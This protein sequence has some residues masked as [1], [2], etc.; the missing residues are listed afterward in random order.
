MKKQY[1]VA[2]FPTA[3]ILVLI[4]VSSAASA[5]IS[6]T[7]IT[8]HGTV[9]NPAIYGNSIAWQD[10]RNGNSTIYVFDTSTKKEIHITDKSN[11]TNP[12]IY[13][14][15]VVWYEYPGLN[16]PTIYT[17]D[18]S[19]KQETPLVSGDIREPAIYGNRVVYFA[20]AG[21]AI[22]IYD[23]TNKLSTMI[24]GP[25]DMAR[26]PTINGNKIVW[27]Y[28][29]NSEGGDISMYDLSTSQETLITTHGSTEKPEIY[30]NKI[31]WQDKRN[32]NWDIYMYD[33]F[34][35]K[36]TQIT[37]NASDSINPVIY[38]NNIVWQDNRNGNWDIYV[39]NLTTH[40]QIHTINKSDQVAPA[41]YSNKVVWTDYRN[42]RPD[43][44]MGT[45]CFLPI[46]AFNA[47]PTTGKH[48]FNVKFT[49]KSTDACSWYW[50]FGDKI[51]SR[52]RNPVHEYTKAGKY[53][54]ALKVKNA[55]GSNIVK[56]TDYITVK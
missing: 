34:T 35:K 4:I 13:G 40:Q 48:P 47:S 46:A 50:D 1:S 2:L 36:E 21:E 12:A 29:Y 10:W 41:I 23:F 39:Y 16:G 27:C 45:F 32:G 54:V 42:G 17:Y 44:Y 33:L 26:E 11:Q 52:L 31:V 51:N 9:S 24:S 43:I 37:T 38:G 15:R 6:E 25:N 19:T 18:L 56:K 7:R 3:V 49:D 22:M 30:D 5:S 55:G 53:T 28:G 20:Q 14:N 8:Y